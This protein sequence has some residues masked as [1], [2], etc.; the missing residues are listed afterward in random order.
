MRMHHEHLL[1]HPR[2]SRT[3]ASRTLAPYHGRPPDKCLITVIG[4]AG[5]RALNR[6]GVTL[7]RLQPAWCNI[8]PVRCGVRAGDPGTGDARAGDGACGRTRKARLMRVHD[9]V[10]GAKPAGYFSTRANRPSAT[11]GRFRVRHRAHVMTVIGAFARKPAVI[12]ARCGRPGVCD[13]RGCGRR[14]PWCIRMIGQVT[15]G[16]RVTKKKLSF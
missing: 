11:L 5:C 6:P 15:Q 7:G 4:W 14:Y 10:A 13:G 9:Y 3:R 2:L 12:R 16:Q 8:G 1:P